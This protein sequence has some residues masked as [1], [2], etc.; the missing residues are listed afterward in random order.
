MVATPEQK[1]KVS[2]YAEENGTINVI[3]Y[4]FRELPNLKESSMRG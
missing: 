1:V 4:F 2:K 3:L